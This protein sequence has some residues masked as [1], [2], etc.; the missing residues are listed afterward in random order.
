MT[1][2]IA[3]IYFITFTTLESLLYFEIF[4]TKSTIVKNINIK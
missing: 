2:G 1:T 3:S 4:N